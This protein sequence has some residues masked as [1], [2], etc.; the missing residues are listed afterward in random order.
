MVLLPSG[1]QAQY[2]PVPGGLLMPILAGLTMP[3]AAAIP[4]AW[5]TTFQ[6]SYP[7]G[8]GHPTPPYAHPIQH[9]QFLHHSATSK[10]SSP[11]R[12]L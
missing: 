8:E 3:Q 2:V 1:G 6:L 9:V 7:L 4:E 10:P 5:L 11:A 12:Q